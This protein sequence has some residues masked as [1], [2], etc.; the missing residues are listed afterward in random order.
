[1]QS[2]LKSPLNSNQSDTVSDYSQLPVPVE[3]HS[4]HKTF[5]C[6]IQYRCHTVTTQ[7]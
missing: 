6:V 2:E 3:E 4:A 5:S 1:M 7:A